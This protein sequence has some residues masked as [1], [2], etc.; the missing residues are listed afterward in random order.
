MARSY[1]DIDLGK[2]GRQIGWLAIEQSSDRSAWGTQLLPIVVLASG[3]P[4]PTVLL[5]AGSHGDE[6]EGQIILSRLINTLVPEDL[7]GRLIILPAANPAAVIAG[8]RVSPIDGGNLNRSF[9]SER[10]TT[11]ADKI[12]EFIKR[13]LLPLADAVVDLHSGGES[14]NILPCCTFGLTGNP[15]FDAQGI[16]LLRAFNAP[17]SLTFR[18]G[19]GYGKL[20]DVATVPTLTTEL[21]GGGAVSRDA[22]EIGMAGV[23]GV[24]SKLG[25][26]ASPYGSLEPR[27]RELNIDSADSFTYA[28]DDGV[29]EPSVALGQHVTRG[30]I[31][32]YIHRPEQPNAKPVPVAI[33]ES[34]FLYAMRAI[35]RVSSGDCVLRVAFSGFEELPPRG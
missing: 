19:K 15:R 17:L 5:M 6:Y 34:G 10:P 28:Y 30:D 31:A 25:I 9:S 4:G 2:S 32:G 24:L 23:Y 14:L 18:A 29:F 33:R 12:A 21:G 16:A 27:A 1:I 11:T 13:D 7:A 35:G 3:K 22:V 8:R 26:A 20:V